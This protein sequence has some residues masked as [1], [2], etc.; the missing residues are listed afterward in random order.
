MT[1]YIKLNKLKVSKKV[2]LTLTVHKTEDCFA[3]I[4]KADQ[5]EVTVFAGDIKTGVNSAVNALFAIF[6]K[7]EV[8]DD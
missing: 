8:E 7:L 3:I 2:V 6:E 1:T 4:A 5:Q